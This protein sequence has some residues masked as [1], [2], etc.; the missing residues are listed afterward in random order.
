MK[1][2]TISPKRLRELIEEEL[3]RSLVTEFVDHSSI[4]AVTGAASKL[5]AA[6]EAF[7]DKMKDSAPAAINAA[8]PHLSE[9]E[10]VLED[11]VTT[12]GSYV[13]VAK[14]EPR[15]ITLSNQGASKK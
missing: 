3:E 15:T 13:P 4:S 11:M 2:L 14:R 5:M 10:R 7:K 12:P 8:T 6:I 1:T 9:L